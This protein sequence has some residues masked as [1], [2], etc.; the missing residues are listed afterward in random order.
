MGE[1]I[2]TRRDFLKVAAGTAMAA[3]LGS[4]VL[5]EAKAA[6]PTT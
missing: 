1:T 6:E 4:G 5:G 2:I 3:T